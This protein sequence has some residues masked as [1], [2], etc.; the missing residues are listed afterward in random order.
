[1]TNSFGSVY[2]HGSISTDRNLD[3]SA[4]VSGSEVPI[5]TSV[6][7]QF[8]LSITNDVWEHDVFVIEIDNDW[9]LE[10]TSNTGRCKSKVSS[11]Q[12][13]YL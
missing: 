11:G 1:M 7:L 10:S 2:F 12:T 13:N 3:I 8:T 6:S 5:A 4:V 9:T